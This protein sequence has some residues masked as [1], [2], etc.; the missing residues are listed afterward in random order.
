[1]GV[2]EGGAC[3]NSLIKNEGCRDGSAKTY[4]CKGKELFHVKNIKVSTGA[5][6]WEK[7]E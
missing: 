4:V 6:L 2:E 7:K 1:M 3:A 5:N